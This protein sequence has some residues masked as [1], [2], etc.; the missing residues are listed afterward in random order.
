MSVRIVGGANVL[1]SAEISFKAAF[2]ISNSLSRIKSSIKAITVSKYF[3]S[4]KFFNLIN[5]I[6]NL[7]IRN[8]TEYEVVSYLIKIL[9]KT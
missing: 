7:Q 3:S 4:I 1:T 8:L 6:K 2:F 9:G 5:S